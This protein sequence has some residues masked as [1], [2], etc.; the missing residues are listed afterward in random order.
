[1]PVMEVNVTTTSGENAHAQSVIDI[2]LDGMLVTFEE[3]AGF[4]VGQR[5][6]VRVKSG[7]LFVMLLASTVHVSHQRDFHTFAAFEFTAHQ[8]EEMTVLARLL[9]QHTRDNEP[10]NSSGARTFV[11]TAGS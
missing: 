4:I 5:V 6:V 8:N 9:R 2:S 3:P 7:D 1:M 11:R 10:I